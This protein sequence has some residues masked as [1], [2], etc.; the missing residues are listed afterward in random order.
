MG[1][2]GTNKIPREISGTLR[3]ARHSVHFHII[4]TQNK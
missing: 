1:K 2:G 4:G 3:A